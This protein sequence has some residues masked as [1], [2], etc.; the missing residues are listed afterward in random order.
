[1]ISRARQPFAGEPTRG[2]IKSAPVNETQTTKAIF[3]EIGGVWIGILLGIP[4]VFP[5]F[6]EG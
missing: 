4:K 2:C 3:L 6:E 5:I 1:M